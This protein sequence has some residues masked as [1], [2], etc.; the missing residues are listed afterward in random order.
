M[1]YSNLQ[2]NDHFLPLLV[3]SSN[4]WEGSEHLP[5]YFLACLSSLA[6]SSWVS[7][8]YTVIE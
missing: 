5:S 7:A 1:F 2:L 6:H 3:V 4:S 8:S